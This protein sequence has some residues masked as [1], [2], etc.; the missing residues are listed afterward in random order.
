MIDGVMRCGR[1]PGE[2]E[3]APQP[4]PPLASMVR[5]R[6]Y[7]QCC[8]HHQNAARA[9]H[10]APRRFYHFHG[11][12]MENVANTTLNEVIARVTNAT[13]LPLSVFQVGHGCKRHVVIKVPCST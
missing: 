3:T 6:T 13:D 7:A 2:T 9:P 12:R 1:A 8:Q 10:G 11:R 4:P 5:L